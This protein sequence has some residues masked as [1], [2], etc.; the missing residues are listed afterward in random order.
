ML[1]KKKKEFKIPRHIAFICDG[2]RRWARMRGLPPTAGHAAGADVLKPLCEYFFSRGVS[3]LSFYIF[4]IENWGRDGKEV[5]FLMEFFENEMPKHV[6]HAHKKNIRIKFIGRRD[7]LPKAVLKMCLKFEKETAANDAGTI[8]FA[9]DYGGQDEILRAAQ[10]YADYMA[11][12]VWDKSAN[13]ATL[14]LETF[15]SFM[16]TGELL[17]IDLLVRSSGEQRISNFML[18]K[19]A[20]AE[21][22]FYPKYW[23]ALKERDFET[24]LSEYSE[25]KRRFGK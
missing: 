20:Y 25:R 5:K 6:A 24:M 3:T 21:L 19:L 17:P 1:F 7:H 15:E 4:S 11:A 16:D 22:I 14:D 12:Q 18:W 9:L 10:A 8:V 23:P 2:N 13:K